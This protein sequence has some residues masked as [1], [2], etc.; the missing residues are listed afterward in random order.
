MKKYEVLKYCEEKAEEGWMTHTLLLELYE[1]NEDIP[2]E[3]VDLVC[4]I[5]EPPKPF[6]LYLGEQGLKDFNR[7]IEEYS[8]TI[9]QRE[10]IDE[11]KNNKIDS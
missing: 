6:V 8:L 3:F 10:I 9:I 4:Y 1:D 5:P 7:A 11:Y 2:D